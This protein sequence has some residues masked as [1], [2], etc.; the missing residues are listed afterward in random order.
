MA[1]HTNRIELKS[2]AEIDKMRQAGKLL[3][4]VYTQV[5]EKVAAGVTTAEL[6]RHARTAGERSRR[7]AG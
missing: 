6:D 1:N 2:P 7:G 5:A 3:R 4:Q